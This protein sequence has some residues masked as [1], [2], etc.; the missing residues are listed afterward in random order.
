VWL[1]RPAQE[2]RA[3]PRRGEP[4]RTVERRPAVSTPAGQ[5]LEAVGRGGRGLCGSEIPPPGSEPGPEVP[6]ALRALSAG[7]PTAEQIQ[8]AVGEWGFDSGEDVDPG[9]VASAIARQRATIEEGLRE[10]RA[11]DDDPELAEVT[12]HVRVDR[13]R[14]LGRPGEALSDARYAYT[15]WPNSETANQLAGL[16]DD[17]GQPAEARRLLEAE[18]G[19]TEDAGERAWL[20][21][22]LG[23][24][25]A[26]RGDQACA[27]RAVAA[28]EKQSEDP[29]LTSFTRAVHLTF[30]DR[31]DEARAAYDQ[32]M[33]DDRDFASLN[34]LAEVEVCAGRTGESRR[35]YLE[36][37]ARRNTPEAAGSALAGLAYTH[38]RDG[39]IV[40][41]WLYASAALAGTG[42]GSHSSDPRGVLALG[43]LTAGDLGEARTQAR[44]ARAANPHDDLVRRRCFAH[45]AEQAAMRALAAEAQGDRSA[46]QAA[47]LEVAR[48][49]HQALSLAAR[50]A[51]RELCP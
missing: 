51:L 38:L 8:A 37:L 4:G 25:C 36:A 24:I 12:L 14:H 32:A 6:S 13:L 19:R 1:V 2:R 18:R 21:A 41:A 48:S 45:P 34:N 27:A 42:E 5:P 29:S 23:F 22:Q 49:G 35:L 16:L 28:L 15:K 31:L 10:A 47:W 30:L 3:A 17:L 7:V 40:P 39:D 33:A 44:L 11:E 50:R 9:A 46:A 43:A 20:D 26:T